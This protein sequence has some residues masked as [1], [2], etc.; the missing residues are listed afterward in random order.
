MFAGVFGQLPRCPGPG[1]YLQPGSIEKLDEGE[2]QHDQHK[3]RA[4]QQHQDGK[5]P[6]QIRVK[7]DVAEAERRHHRQGP[8]HTGDPGVLLSLAYHQKMEQDG[9]EGD[10]G[11]DNAH[12]FEQDLN[13]P[14]SRPVKKIGQLAEDKLHVFSEPSQA[15]GK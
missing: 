2:G 15:S 12:E 7:G 5:E 3:H 8:V 1:L 14:L 9:V 11:R 13:V 6:A 4:G 10:H